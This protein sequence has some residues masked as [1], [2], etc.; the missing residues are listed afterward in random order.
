MILHTTMSTMT[1]AA[2]HRRARSTGLGL[3]F[4]ICAASFGPLA[5]TKPALARVYLAPQPPSAPANAK[6]PFWARVKSPRFIEV[7]ELVRRATVLRFQVSQNYY[8]TV[9]WPTRR[10]VLRDAAALYLDAYRLDGTRTDLLVEAAHVSFEAADF[11]GAEGLYRELRERAEATY[12]GDTVVRY[13]HAEALLRLGLASDAVA[14]LEDALGGDVAGVERAR[15]LTLLG[16][17]YMIERR[18][19]DAAEVCERAQELFRQ[20]YGGS[21][22]VVALALLA[23]IY[24]RDEQSARAAST[25]EALTNADPSFGAVFVNAPLYGNAQPSQ[26]FYL[27]FSP[28]ADKHYFAALL[29]QTQGRFSDAA[30]EWRAYLASAEPAFAARARVHLGV[31]VAEQDKALAAKKKRVTRPSSPPPPPPPPGGRP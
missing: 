2:T 9:M 5:I 19:D 28:P 13:N 31:A 8:E 6:L 25:I 29:F 26:R 16:Y 1:R 7:T 11:A 10:R 30:A 23:I 17:A 22:D 20:M 3:F 21:D 27:P 15:F 14:A 12:L 4:I 18:L 24:D